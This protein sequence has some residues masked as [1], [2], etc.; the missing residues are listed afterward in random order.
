MD[1]SD[2]SSSMMAARK[3]P[4]WRDLPPSASDPATALLSQMDKVSLLE[5]RLPELTNPATNPAGAVAVVRHGAKTYCF[6]S[7]CPSC[8]I[9]LTKAKVTD[10]QPPS[11]QTGATKASTVILSCTFC[12][13]SYDLATGAR[14]ESPPQKWGGGIFSGVVSNIM[15]ADPRSAGPLRL[16]KLSQQGG[17]LMI[18]ID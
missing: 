13:A 14:V 4:N 6:D 8:K 17:K 2:G 1:A 9:P 7:S 10:R 5:T 15:A 12:S 3:N 18:S 11:P 16:F